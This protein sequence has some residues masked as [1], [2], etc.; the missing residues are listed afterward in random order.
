MRG[1][2]PLPSCMVNVSDGRLSTEMPHMHLMLLCA[3]L[4]IRIIVG[5]FREEEHYGHAICRNCPVNRHS[6]VVIG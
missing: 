1:V 2:Q 6:A 3:Y 4:D 5:L